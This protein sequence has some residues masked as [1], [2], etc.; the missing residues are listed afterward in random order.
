[1]DE[2][3]V[4][5]SAPLISESSKATLAAIRFDALLQFITR[6]P[7]GLEAIVWLGLSMDWVIWTTVAVDSRLRGSG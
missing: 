1:M 4:S 5:E 3:W 2:L 6:R 7:T